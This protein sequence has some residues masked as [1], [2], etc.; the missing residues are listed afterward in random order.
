MKSLRIMVIEDYDALRETICA[1]LQ[2]DGHETCGV[3]SAEDVD[4][5]P[6]GYVPDLYIVDINLPGENG[7]SLAKRI[8]RSQPDAG[9]VIVSA[10]TAL[11]DRID[12]YKSGANLYLTKPIQL[13][14]LRAVVGGFGQR[15][16][17]TEVKHGGHIS[18]RPNK[19]DLAGPAKKVRLTQSEVVLLAAFSR[20]AQQ[21]L[22]HWQVEAHLGNGG[23]LTKGNLE[24]RLG[25]LRKKLIACGAE[26]PAI[27][28]I[29]GL[30]YRLCETV[31]ILKE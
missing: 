12:S 30:G 24:V 15:L 26:A 20:A 7:I 11:S 14:E 8:N 28:S 10:R 9:I 13:D 23:D 29:R 18:L 27:K 31:S 3:P 16:A 6:V 1:V 25:R 22:E 19:M 4:D 5:T 21:T 2:A 17:N